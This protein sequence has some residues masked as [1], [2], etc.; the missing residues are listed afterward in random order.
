MN[1]PQITAGIV[2]NIERIME[3]TDSTSIKLIRN[4]NL[5]KFKLNGHF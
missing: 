1:P 5:N 2:S 3:C 4:K